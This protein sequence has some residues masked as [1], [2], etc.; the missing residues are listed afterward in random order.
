MPVRFLPDNMMNIQSLNTSPESFPAVLP[1]I[2]AERPKEVPV[3]PDSVEISPDAQIVQDQDTIG[4]ADSLPGQGSV[5]KNQLAFGGEDQPGVPSELTSEDGHLRVS[6]DGSQA[7]V[8]DE[9]GEEEEALVTDPASKSTTGEV[10]SG[11]DREEVRNLQ[12]RDREV[13]THEQAHVAAGGSYVRGGIQYEYQTGPD[14]RRYAVGGEVSIDTSPVS[15]DPQKTIQKAQQIRRAALALAEPS[16]ADRSAAAAA[17]QMEAQ[18]RQELIEERSNPD[19][20]STDAAGS[21][22][23]DQDA[24][25]EAVVSEAGSQEVASTEVGSDTPVNVSTS[26]T[27]GLGD[28]SEDFQIAPPGEVGAFEPAQVPE[29]SPNIPGVGDVASPE[30]GLSAIADEEE[31]LDDLIQDIQNRTNSGSGVTAQAVMTLS[32]GLGSPEIGSRLDFTT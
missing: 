1:G 24:E 12:E 19:E 6:G 17:S 31:G 16:G 11:E 29:L 3:V 9:E 25:T 2:G 23:V 15:G 32:Y 7:S 30:A 8:D 18:A 20:G 5:A 21:V 28:D 13:R 22:G 4:S 27:E 10:L 26:I 14:G